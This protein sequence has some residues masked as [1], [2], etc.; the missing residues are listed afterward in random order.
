[1][2]RLIDAAALYPISYGD[3]EKMDNKNFYFLF[4]PIVILLAGF[5]LSDGADDQILSVKK[6]LGK[7]IFF[8]KQLSLKRNQS[9]ASCH[10]PAAGWTGP[11]A[12]VNA[13]EAVYQAL[14]PAAAETANRRVLPMQQLTPNCICF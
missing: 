1:M 3:R 9:C 8:D 12:A 6:Q 10:D 11:D 7:S 4:F 14:L 13:R 2:L 5:N